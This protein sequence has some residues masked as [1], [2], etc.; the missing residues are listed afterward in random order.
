MSKFKVSDNSPD[1]AK[2]EEKIIDNWNEKNIFEKSV[3]G[4]AKFIFYDGPPFA[5]GLP[6]YGHLI[7]GFIKD[8]FAR[9]KTMDGCKV[10]R[11]FGWD[12][13]G[14]PVEMGVEKKTGISGRLKIEE[15]GIDKFNNECSKDVM[16]Y[17]SE[18]KQ[19]IERQARWVDFYNG[20]K[21]M[22][23]SCMESVLWAFKNLYEKGLIYEDY[24]VV[25][26]SWKCQTPLSQFETRMD[27]SYREKT[28]KS[29]YVTFELTSESRD[30]FL[31][32]YSYPE[33][34]KVK[35]VKIMVWTTTPWT[36]PSNLILAIGKDVDYIIKFDEN[37]DTAYIISSKSKL[38]DEKGIFIDVEGDELSVNADKLE[39]LSYLPM[40]PYFKNN[41]NSFKV[42]IADFV[43]DEDGTGIVHVA[44]GFG[45]D[46]FILCKNNK[47]P[48][49]CPVDEGGNFTNEV[50]DFVGRNV[51]EAT[52]D[53]I[54]FLKNMGVWKFTEQ[55]L[56]NYPHCWRTD[57][58]LIYKAVSSWY[59]RV[60]S[61]KDRMIELNKKINWI[62]NH[63]KD[64]QFGKWIE[65]AR[66]WAISRNRF[67]GTPIP[68]WKSDNPENKKLYVF[69]SIKELEDFF[70]VN[71]DDLHRP[72]I[73]SLVK[74]DPYDSNFKIKRVYDVLDC[75]FESGSMPY[76]QH[77]FPYSSEFGNIST[78]ED[79][80]NNKD[81]V[82][83][84]FKDQYFPSD[85]I[86]EY[87]AQT[88]GWF[89]TLNV[90]STA[91]FDDI[92][93]K[94]CIC[95]G[96]V[97][98]ASGQKLS[99]RLNNYSSPMEMFNKYGSDAL[100]FLMMSHPIVT[101]DNL[102]LDKDGVLI[103]DEIR[104]TIKPLFNALYFFSVYAE[105]DNINYE[106][107]K[108][109]TIKDCLDDGDIS[110]VQKLL[111][112][113]IL[114]CCNITVANI[115]KAMS[116]YNSS[117]ACKNITNFIDQLNNWYIRRSRKIFWDKKT[118]DN[119]GNKLLAYKTLY[120]VLYKLAVISA[121]L[122]PLLSEYIYGILTQNRELESVHLCDLNHILSDFKDCYVEEN[123][124]DYSNY[125]SN[126]YNNIKSDDIAIINSCKTLSLIK[127]KT[128]FSENGIRN[129]YKSNIQQGVLDGE[130]T[131]KI[132]DR[133]KMIRDICTVVISIR[134]AIKI[135]V[136]QPL[137]ALYI[138]AFYHPNIYDLYIDNGLK[139]F[140]CDGNNAE[141]G[142]E[143]ERGK[144]GL[145]DILFEELNVEHIY[146][147]F[148]L[149]DNFTLKTE[150]KLNF[151]QVREDVFTDEQKKDKGI[152]KQIM[153]AVKT[154]NGIEYNMSND[155][156]NKSELVFKYRSDQGVQDI[157]LSS[158]KGDF[159]L[160]INYNE[161]K[162][163]KYMAKYIDDYGLGVALD[164]E[165]T[166]D[167]KNKGIARTLL[168]FIQE[169]RKS[170][171]INIT[172]RIECYVDCNSSDFKNVIINDDLRL[173]VQE[174]TLSNSIELIE[175]IKDI[176][177]LYSSEFEYE[178]DKIIIYIKK[179]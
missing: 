83:K 147:V 2:I 99:K 123:F 34:Q 80:I 156:N 6:H 45:E 37:R 88:R 78:Y 61:V 87:I 141:I 101:G 143:L 19:Y 106:D 118:S 60:T 140:K 159:T 51:F 114:D 174:N 84:K 100:R 129:I 161:K 111:N 167:L 145:F 58:P 165:V 17:T 172:D 59:L 158:Y 109:I 138:H 77:H 135:S 47:I 69:G 16:K 68:I 23:K 10:N 94:N 57:T 30:K 27:N 127:A 73:D 1:I 36:L 41:S 44:P 15:Y 11:V 67:W 128:L 122:L 155:I 126:M 96:V 38:C 8:A 132:I 62:P 148:N 46:D 20:Y 173:Y 39:G 108:L 93:F 66:D 48:L 98:D 81:D 175:D 149:P 163:C 146:W 139:V 89:Y 75:W 157:Y 121:P 85:F 54:K 55:Y 71:I 7:T 70:E 136:R 178:N 107:M 115:Y 33:L 74:D 82:D 120:T 90:L 179:D 5:N 25:P 113:Y 160:N 18:W 21:T 24:K 117:I 40:F 43:T 52:D 65:G 91:L 166:S 104:L 137:E 22:N 171:G 125:I 53:V 154:G 112:I 49:V 97:L 170:M 151:K 131:Y 63:I 14:L 95:H 86:V 169:T 12:C 103:K 26:Y 162:D 168:R 42:L 3:R 9:F 177:K 76:S 50:S 176:D 64:G 150:I 133:M 92:P 31:S 32:S 153:S 28:S 79:Y 105:A 13:H 152:M 119:E 116:D 4:D 35:S 164:I 124:N 102:L 72:Y 130:V 110:D 144:I 134:N 142:W 56:H 29:V